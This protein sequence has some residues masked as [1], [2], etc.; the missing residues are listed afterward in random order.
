MERIRITLRVDK[1]KSSDFNQYLNDMVFGLRHNAQ[2]DDIVW[3]DICKLVL[4]VSVRDRDEKWSV[5][6]ELLTWVYCEQYGESLDII[7]MQC[8]SL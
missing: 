7:E 1:R 4:I 2:V 3:I 8:Y 6:S 5:L